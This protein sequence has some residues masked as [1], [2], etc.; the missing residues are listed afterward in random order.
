[1]MMM[2]MRLPEKGQLL[3]RGKMRSGWLDVQTCKMQMLMRRL[4]TPGHVKITLIIAAVDFGQFSLHSTGTMMDRLSLYSHF[5]AC[6]KRPNTG[7]F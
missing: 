1:M 6:V 3:F 5:T 2:M 4:N 7:F